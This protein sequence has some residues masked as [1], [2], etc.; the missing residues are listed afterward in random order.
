MIYGAFI[1]TQEAVYLNKYNQNKITALVLD[2]TISS[3]T[4]IAAAQSPPASENIIRQN[5]ISPYSAKEDIKSIKDI[6]EL[7]IY[8]QFDEQVPFKE[9]QLVFKN[10]L[11]PKSFFIYNGRHLQAMRVDPTG[12]MNEINKLIH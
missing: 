10:A 12:V 7:F 6:P 4:A 9:E 3:F 5:L 8:S 11:G 1:G 2:G